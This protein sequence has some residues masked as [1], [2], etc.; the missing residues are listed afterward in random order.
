MKQILITGATGF[1]GTQILKALAGV[2]V[3][4]I[5]VVR[6][7][8]ENQVSSQPN[9]KKILSSTDI[10]AESEDWWVQAC[11]SVDTV[12]HAAWYVEPGDYL[13]SSHNLDCL[14]GSLKMAK[15]AYRAGVKKFV[16]IGTCLEYDLEPSVLSENTPLKPMTVYASAKAALFL[17]LSQWFFDRNINFVW[18]RLFYMYGEGEDQRRLVP[19]IHKQ[20]QNSAPV[21]LSSG[22]Q[23]R[24]FMDV[25]YVGKKIVDISLGKIVGPV[26][27]CSGKPVSVRQLAEKIALDYGRP[28]LLRFGTRSKN[29]D[30]PASVVGV[31]I[32]KQAKEE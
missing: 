17:A 26:N 6:A 3:D 5:L 23:I 31:T 27:V 13:H 4:V 25:K 9:V 11:A 14:I 12:I 32:H 15:G 20:M 8:G 1:V 21:E 16:G 7:G 19:Y 2:S 30:D 24:D 29:T 10:F 28:D 22:E 18:C